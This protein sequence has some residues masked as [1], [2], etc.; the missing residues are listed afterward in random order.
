MIANAPV[1]VATDFE[2]VYPDASRSATECA[3][4][5]VKTGDLVV[6]RVAEVLRPFGL[7]PAG[8][9]VLSMLADSRGALTPGVIRDGLLV[10]GPTVTGLIDNL[11]A[12]GLVRRTQD[13][14]DRRRV[15]VELTQKGLRLASRFRPA[16]HAA[17][18]PWLECLD[19]PDRRRLIGLLGRVQSHLLSGPA[20]PERRA[21]PG[22]RDP[23]QA[24]PRRQISRTP[25]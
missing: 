18:R 20:D 15:L 10:K 16:V 11:A 1:R 4:N 22:A 19:E 14:Q 17:Q 24:A 8:G 2:R 13:P 9:L 6:S 12:A 25:K 7:S 5:L 21:F 3:M 23:A